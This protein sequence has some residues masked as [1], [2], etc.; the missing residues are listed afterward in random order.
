MPDIRK[1]AGELDIADRV[2]FAGL[3]TDV[4]ACYQAMDVFAFPSRY[5]GSPGSVM[6]AQAAALPCLIS[7]QITGDVDVTDRITR[8]CIGNDRDPA[9]VGKARDQWAAKLLE[10]QRSRQG[11][12]RE[13]LSG[14]IAAEL[15]E[16]GFDAAKQAEWLTHFYLTGEVTGGTP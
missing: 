4:A 16:A 8:M 11:E 14:R 9:S 6:E 10:L 15:R 2:I 5:E 13:A 12:N 1:L 7:D 3:R